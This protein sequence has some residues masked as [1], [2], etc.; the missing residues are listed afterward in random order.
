MAKGSN[1]KLKILYILDY[2][3]ENTDEDNMVSVKDIISYLE[4]NGI[5]A[6]RKSVYSDIEA[7]KAYGIDIISEKSKTYG[8]GIASRD[9]ELAELKMLVDSVQASR[10]ITE[11][12]SSGIIKKI[13]KLTSRHQAHTLQRQVY[14]Q[15]RAKTANEKIYYIVDAIYEA[16]SKNKKISFKYYEYGTDKKKHEK[17]NG[18]PYIV[19][20]YSL[21]VSDDNY[22]MIANYPKYDGLTHFRTDRM[23][24]VKILDENSENIESVTYEKFNLGDYSK[25]VFQ[26]FGGE[27][28]KVTLLCKKNMINAVI[29]KFGEDV[30]IIKNDDDTF[31]ASVTV[32]VS[33]TFFAW[34]FTFSGSMKI[35]SPTSVRDKFNEMLKSF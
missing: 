34:I 8:Y 27:T 20:P 29:D 7:L 22:Y 19:S 13:E 33:P 9:F 18:M 25:K 16:I 26:M 31:N 5:T 4:Q 2:L 3:M 30:M 35:I 11:K 17:N 6:E 28:E 12:K 10:F 15:E 1:Q 32:K 14:I 23:G 24:E 21:T